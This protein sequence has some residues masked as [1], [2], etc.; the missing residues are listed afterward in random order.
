MHLVLRFVFARPLH[1]RKP[2]QLPRVDVIKSGNE[3]VFRDVLQELDPACA[4]RLLPFRLKCPVE[5]NQVK[6][7]PCSRKRLMLQRTGGGRQNQFIPKPDGLFLCSE[8]GGK[9]N[10]NKAQ[11]WRNTAEFHS[12]NLSH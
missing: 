6:A 1:E 10:T 11:Q 4:Q 9:E 5:L 2:L 7:V 8:R 12:Q 3:G